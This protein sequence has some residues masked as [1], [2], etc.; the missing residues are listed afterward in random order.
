MLHRNLECV[1]GTF[2]TTGYLFIFEMVKQKTVPPEHSGQGAGD[3]SSTVK[4]A[5][6]G[7]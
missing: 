3:W 6:S 4:L 2:G 5:G 1:F 7:P